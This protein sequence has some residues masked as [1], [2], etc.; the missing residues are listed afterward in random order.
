MKEARQDGDAPGG[1]LLGRRDSV[2]VHQCP[3]GCLH[4]TVGGTTLHLGAGEWRRLVEVCVEA[5]VRL[6]TR[7]AAFRLG[8]H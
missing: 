5:Q 3:G 8:L 4:L 2:A 1:E 7:E 6:E